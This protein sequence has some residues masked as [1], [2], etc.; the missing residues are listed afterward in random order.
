MKIID[1]FIF[2]NEYDLL[3]YRLN[4]LNDHVDYFILVESTH[5]FTGNKK[6]LFY[7]ENKNLFE[8]FNHKIVHI[9][10]ED[11]PYK[12]PNINFHRNEQWHNES[13]QRI[14]IKRGI[15]QLKLSDEDVIL[16]SDLD[17]IPD[18]NI[19]I[20]LRNNTLSYNKNTLNRLALDM[21]YYNLY[22]KIGEG[23]NWHGIKLL[24]FFAYKNIQLTFQ[25]MRT[26]EHSHP[27][28]IIK[29]GGWHLTY[30]GNSDFIINKLQNYSHQEHNNQTIANKEYI[31]KCIEGG[32]KFFDGKEKLNYIKIEDNTYLPYQYDIYLR[33]YYNS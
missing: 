5:S 28:P 29:N 8:R 11:F 7:N 24:T 26:W 2:F 9:I 18:P 22:L 33:K 17:E 14:C 12:A 30:F 32:I 20:K 1:S 25:Q 15:D 27:V 13:F 21:Y 3:N 10:V 23:S 31:E 4:I 16:T 6:T 19:L